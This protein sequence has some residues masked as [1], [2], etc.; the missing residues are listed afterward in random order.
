MKDYQQDLDQLSN[1]FFMEA[2]PDA[3]SL[4]ELY[5]QVY[6]YSQC[7]AYM[8]A[9]IE[10]LEVTG[11][12]FDDYH[13]Q[14]VQKTLEGDELRQLGTWQAMDE[15][16]EL[17]VSL[18]IGSIV[19]GVDYGTDDIEIEA[20]QLNEESS[21]YRNRFYEALKEVE[22]QAEAIWQD[23]H[24]C[25]SCATNFGIDLDEEHSPVWTECPNCKGNGIS[26]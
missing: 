2:F 15:R 12:C 11:T 4:S 16:G 14:I 10:Y 9:T 26:I 13:E 20:K 23:T 17:V 24:G 19:E 18:A 3:E 1:K 8:C 5:R 21:E 6:K 22:Q 7:G 25:K